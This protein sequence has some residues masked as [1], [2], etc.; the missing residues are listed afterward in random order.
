MKTR[1][2]VLNLGNASGD[3]KGQRASSISSLRITVI[4]TNPSATIAALRTAATLAADLHGQIALVCAQAVPAHFAMEYPPVSVGF[5]KRQLYGLVWDAGI[6]QQDIAIEVWLCRD[7]EDALRRIVAPRSLV[8]LGENKH[9]WSRRDR[10]L[11]HFL[12]SLGHHVI[13]AAQP[14][15]TWSQGVERH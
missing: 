3:C 13:S 6:E 14:A 7:R 11:E 8:V 2:Q 9:W 10:N 4:H 1:L 15:Q 12:S 5:L